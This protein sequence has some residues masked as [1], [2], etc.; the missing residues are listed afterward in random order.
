VITAQAALLLVVVVAVAAWGNIKLLP[1][2]AEGSAVRLPVQLA[3]VGQQAMLLAESREQ[4]VPSWQQ[5]LA[6]PSF[7]HGLYPLGQLFSVRLRS[8]STSKA[9][10]LLVSALAGAT[11]GLFVSLSLDRAAE[12]RNA[13]AS[14][15]HR[16]A[17]ILMRWLNSGKFVSFGLF[18]LVKTG[19]L[20]C[21]RR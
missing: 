16:M 2:V 20:A 10:W 8:W 13:V 19:R 7:E 15:I 11:K 18:G 12:A 14:Q 1:S 4:I 6:L 5:A 3:P 9:R 17:R 21:R